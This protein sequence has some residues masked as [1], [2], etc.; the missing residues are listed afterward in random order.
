MFN[1]HALETAIEEYKLELSLAHADTETCLYNIALAHFYLGQHD[2]SI[3]SLNDI[4]PLENLEK[5][6]DALDKISQSTSFY[7]CCLLIE[8]FIHE[9]QYP[10]A[11]SLLKTAFTKFDNSKLYIYLHRLKLVEPLSFIQNVHFGHFLDLTRLTFTNLFHPLTEEQEVILLDKKELMINLKNNL[12]CVL[13]S[14]K[15]FETAKCLLRHLITIN[16]Q[17]NLKI[18]QSNIKYV[19]SSQEKKK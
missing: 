19:Q 2:L 14:L 5:L 12:A 18:I 9:N 4:V 11:V 10:R 3:K 7:I 17:S 1:N 15:A 6:S 8:C 16:P 13:V